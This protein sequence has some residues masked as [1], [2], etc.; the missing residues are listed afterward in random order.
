MALLMGKIIQKLRKEQNLTQEQVA[1][2]LGVTTAAV[3]KWETDSTYPDI[4]LLSPLARLLKTTVDQLVSF[5][6]ELSER[7]VENFE[8][9]ARAIFETGD[10]QKAM[11]YCAALLKEYPSDDMLRFRLAST[12][13]F[14]LSASSDEE[15]AEYQLAETIRLFETVR[16]SKIIEIRHATL[17]VLSSL[18]T[19]ND[20]LDKAKQAIEELP[21]AD[22]DT[23]MMKTN[24]LYMKEEYEESLKLSQLCLFQELRDAGLHLY[25]LAKIA[26]K[27]EQFEK[28]VAIANL[29]IQLDQLL[30]VDRISGSNANYYLFKAEILASQGETESAIDELENFIPVLKTAF[31]LKET[32]G[33]LL[34]DKIELKDPSVSTSYIAE[35]MADLI[36]QSEEFQP[37]LADDRFVDLLDKLR[38]LG[39]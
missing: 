35:R 23:R 14:Y 2:A 13:I 26:R 16:S 8:S 3:S 39:S 5:K 7:E 15:Q 20:E 6:G 11:D 9:E 22:Y 29:G 30:H 37:L 28:A 12:Y 27:Y 19:M 36:E 4:S 25:N 17:Q 34:F 10:S 21:S 38:S 1:N 31:D 33:D 32:K 24:I 18:Y